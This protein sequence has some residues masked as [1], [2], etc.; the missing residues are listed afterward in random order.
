MFIQRNSLCLVLKYK[1][2]KHV[3]SSLR[4]VFALLCKTC[5][6]RTRGILDQVDQVFW[7]IASINSFWCAG[8]SEVW[9]RAYHM[10]GPLDRW[11]VT[12]HFDIYKL[13]QCFSVPQI[14][15]FQWEIAEHKVAQLKIMEYRGS[16]ATC[17]ARSW[18]L[19]RAQRGQL[20]FSC[21]TRLYNVMI[22]YA[23]VFKSRFSHLSCFDCMFQ[24]F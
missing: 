22:R 19:R 18:R 1:W 24:D 16:E 14:L 2:I 4:S 21:S 9:S 6:M 13:L 7:G 5:K 17:G 3:K 23:V 15:T 8:L 10:A 12:C 11:L 20:W